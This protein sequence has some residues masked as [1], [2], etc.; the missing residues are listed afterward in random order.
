M[1]EQ[2]EY[3]F[4]ADSLHSLGDKANQQWIYKLNFPYYLRRSNEGGL[5]ERNIIARTF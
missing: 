4:T 5:D 3:S 1:L 2:F